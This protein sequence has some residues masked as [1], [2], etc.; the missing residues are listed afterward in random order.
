MFITPATVFRVHLFN[1]CW[2]H[3]TDV[4]VKKYQ[5]KGRSYL[6]GMSSYNHLVW[7]YWCAAWMKPTVRVRK[8]VKVFRGGVVSKFKDII[9]AVLCYNFICKQTTLKGWAYNLGQLLCWGWWK[10]T[11][12]CQFRPTVAFLSNSKMSE[13]ISDSELIVP[14][15]NFVL[16]HS[17]NKPTV[18]NKQC[19][20]DY[21]QSR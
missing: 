11:W 8:R 14:N 4:C 15:R 20:A 9:S 13:L 2:W 7:L 12:G 6:G 18:K 3:A 16:W 1:H 5:C 17:S 21:K 19:N 10:R